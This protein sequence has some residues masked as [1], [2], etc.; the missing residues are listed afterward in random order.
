[1]VSKGVFWIVNVGS[2]WPQQ[3][4][5]A[6]PHSPDWQSNMPLLLADLILLHPVSSVEVDLK[7][8]PQNS[9]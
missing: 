2:A 5:R 9:S 8:M 6:D 1:M 3:Q 4:V 7:T